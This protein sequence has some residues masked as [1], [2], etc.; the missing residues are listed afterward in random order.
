V[1]PDSATPLSVVGLMRAVERL[2]VVRASLVH[3]DAQPGDMPH[4]W[5]DISRAKAREPEAAMED[6]LLS[7]VR[8]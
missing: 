5:A 1:S 4:T 3:L 2:M 8:W 6:G 7:F